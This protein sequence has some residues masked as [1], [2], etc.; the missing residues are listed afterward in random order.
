VVM[1]ITLERLSQALG[2]WGPTHHAPDT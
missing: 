1:A 2:S